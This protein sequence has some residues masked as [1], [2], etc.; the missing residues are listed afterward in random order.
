MLSPELIDREPS[1]ATD[2]VRVTSRSAMIAF[3]RCPRMDY[4]GYEWNGTGLVPVKLVV[5]LATGGYVHT[6]LGAVT[7]HAIGGRP[8]PDAQGIDYIVADV[9][10]KY[11]AEVERR[12]IQAEENEDIAYTIA[13]QRA[14]TEA[15]I[16]LAALRVIPEM[17]ED[18]EVL[19]V[20]REDA[21]LLTPEILLQGRA[22]ALLRERA[23]GDLYVLSWK[24][25]KQWDKRKDADARYDMQG[26][27]EA[28]LIERRFAE[29]AHQIV[30]YLEDPEQLQEWRWSDGHLE[31]VR[32]LDHEVLGIPAWFPKY[33]AN[34]DLGHPPQI[35]GI[36]M[37]H[38]LK[39]RREESE[40]APGRWEHK[41]PLIRGY[42][43]PTGPEPKYAWSYYWTCS[44]THPM[45]KSQYYPDGRCPGGRKH[46]LGDAYQPF[47]A[48][49]RMGVKE[50]IEMLAAGAVQPEAGDCL[51]KQHVSPMP[52]ARSPT[53]REAWLT[54]AREQEEHVAL[55]SRRQIRLD[56]DFP[57]YTHSC[58]YPGKCAYIPLCFE[59]PELA[60]DPLA[61]GL[62]QI[63]EPHHPAPTEEEATA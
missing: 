16:R 44:E 33:A 32:R 29:W 8:L 58:T 50:W 31:V 24:T 28:W 37:V 17:L 39:G 3:Q 40:A 59:S 36:K 13:E 45:R 6:G 53:Q 42:V 56:K 20:E 18:F 38:L 43:D 14:L 63:R 9:L 25:T 22:D 41:S 30:K 51:G 34:L 11:D 10:A 12:G 57:Q 55:A 62:Y 60:A 47:Y 61:T 2:A 35:L 48:W 1:R 7:G 4:W 5:P 15:L 54:Q 27:S 21:A 23:S 52:Y 49:E 19:E 46:R 26:I